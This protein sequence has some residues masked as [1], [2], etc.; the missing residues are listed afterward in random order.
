M[1]KRRFTMSHLDS[2]SANHSYKVVY[3]GD[4]GGLTSSSI[5]TNLKWSQD[6]EQ[7]KRDLSYLLRHEVVSFKAI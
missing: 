7:M 3:V 6:S 5:I 4:Q 1:R 2:I